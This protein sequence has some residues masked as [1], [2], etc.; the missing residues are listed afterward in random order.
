MRLRGVATC[1][2][3]GWKISRHTPHVTAANSTS[4]NKPQLWCSRSRFHQIWWYRHMY[5]A[6]LNMF[7]TFRFASASFLWNAIS[8]LT[9]AHRVN[10]CLHSTLV[11]M[12]AKSSAARANSPP[13]A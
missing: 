5:V 6:I 8:R 1:L 10:A 12:S 2:L 4:K 7:H 11:I 13:T 9:R 3:P